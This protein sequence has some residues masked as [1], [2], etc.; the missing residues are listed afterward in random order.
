MYKLIYILAEN[1]QSIQKLREW[2]KKENE[3]TICY[4]QARL[5]MK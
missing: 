1:G 2:L 5:K 3:S 4:L